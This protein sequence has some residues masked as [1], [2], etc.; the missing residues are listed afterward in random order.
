MEKSDPKKIYDWTVCPD[1]FLAVALVMAN[2]IP[3]WLLPKDVLQ[4][5]E[6]FRELR[7]RSSHANYELIR[8]IIFNFKQGIELYIKGLGN[9]VHGEYVASHDLK[10]LFDVVV[11][12]AGRDPQKASNFK[13]LKQLRNDTWPV[14]KKYYFGTYI[15]L[16]RDELHPD[17]DNEAER[18]PEERRNRAGK[19]YVIPE[20]YKWVTGEVIDQIKADI[21]FLESKLAQAKR[22]IK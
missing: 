8:P 12:K 2:K 3:Y 20:L 13:V 18:Y 11:E 22:D 1:A 9:V 7:F 15:P 14:I 21:I 17:K 4:G 6:V 10:Q 16:V 19:I 5:S